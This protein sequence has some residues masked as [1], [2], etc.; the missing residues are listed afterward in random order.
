MTKA[1]QLCLQQLTPLFLWGKK[2]PTKQPAAL[3]WRETSH[4]FIQQQ[5]MQALNSEGI[6]CRMLHK[7]KL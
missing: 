1:T 6:T 4:L 5:E 7:Q 2:N 3:V